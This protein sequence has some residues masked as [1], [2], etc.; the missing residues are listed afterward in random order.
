MRQRR[1]E[2]CGEVPFAFEESSLGVERGKRGLIHRPGETKGSLI[3]GNQ[4]SHKYRIMIKRQ[5]NLVDQLVGIAR[6]LSTSRESRPKRVCWGKVYFCYRWGFLLD[7]D[8]QISARCRSSEVFWS[9]SF[10][11]RSRSKGY[12]NNRRW[13]HRNGWTA[14]VCVFCYFVEEAHVFKSALMPIKI[15][16][17]TDKNEKYDVEIETVCYL[18]ICLKFRLL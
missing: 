14:C 6:K 9:T 1:P 10:A 18:F 15:S 2:S 17:R 8:A 7:R 12:R 3:Q 4:E 11:R 5:R 13:G 16:F